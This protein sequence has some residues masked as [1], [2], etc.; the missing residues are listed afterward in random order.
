M[1]DVWILI[2]LAFIQILFNR[3][4]C[5]MSLWCFLLPFL[6][7]TLAAPNRTAVINVYKAEK[8]TS[9]PQLSST[10]KNDPAI[11]ENVRGKYSELGN[12]KE[13]NGRLHMMSSDCDSDD[14]RHFARLPE[15][16]IA[17]FH[18]RE[19]S[20]SSVNDLHKECTSM[21][22]RM[23]RALV[24]GA[25]AIIILTLNPRILKEFEGKQMFSCPVIIVEALENVTNFVSIL[26]SKMKMKAKIYQAPKTSFPTLTLWAMCGRPTNG[27]SYHEWDGV[28]CMGTEEESSG[29]ADP[30]S[31]WNFF[32]SGTFLILMLLA[33]KSRR[34]LN[35][36]WGEESEIESA[37]RDLTFK[38]LSSMKTIKLKE[39]HLNPNALCAICLELFNRKQK[40][41]VLPCSHE[42]HTKCVDPWLLNNR[43][44]PLCKL[45]IVDEMAKG[46]SI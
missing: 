1:T 28:V 29:K 27:H 6:V 22:D 31:F 8:P 44:C 15:N 36:E 3:K 41:R 24:F 13:T 4:R 11:A 37:L 25:S 21:I 39:N 45:N 17:V 20:G 35:N 30:V 5:T 46:G 12:V 23:Q 32:Y 40:L 9:R 7:P 38:A 34:R 14:E 19:R 33:I 16:W 10:I 42:F 43:T 2:H 26:K 18:L